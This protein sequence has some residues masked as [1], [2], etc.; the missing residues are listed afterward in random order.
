M[1]SVTYFFNP[2]RLLKKNKTLPNIKDMSDKV[3]SKE[4][5]L[6]NL[7][8]TRPALLT[9]LKFINRS[10]V[11]GNLKHNKLFM[12]FISDVYCFLLIECVDEP[13]VILIFDILSIS[14]AGI[15]I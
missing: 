15:T 4:I 11:T 6:N 8:Y 12:V 1:V 3:L 13:L 14:F 10:S 9:K 5:L 2:I 7:E